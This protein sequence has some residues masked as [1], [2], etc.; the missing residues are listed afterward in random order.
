MKQR[1]K[2]SDYNS[3]HKVLTCHLE[4]EARDMASSKQFSGDYGV[5]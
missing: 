3:H 5:V 1:T 4:S 2:N